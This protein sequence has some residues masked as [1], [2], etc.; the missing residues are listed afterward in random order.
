MNPLDY[1]YWFETVR[2]LIIISS[3]SVALAAL[4]TRWIRS[5]SW[6]RTIW[7]IAFLSIALLSISDITGLT[8]GMAL[9]FGGKKPVAPQFIVK[10]MIPT[11]KPTLAIEQD[12]S[13]ATE[14]LP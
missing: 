4:A 13:T 6:Q 5:A 11:S 2:N 14:P 8:K 3:A 1:G 12:F 9:W 10:T 7:Q